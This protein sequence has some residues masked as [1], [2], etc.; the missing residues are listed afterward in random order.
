MKIKEIFEQKK[1]VISLE[2]FPPSKNY[3]YSRLIYDLDKF[4]TLDPDFISVTYSD[5]RNKREVFLKIND[6][7]KN[8]LGIEALSHLTCVNSTVAGVEE[9]LK[10][11]QDINVKNVLALRGDI[12]D[13]NDKRGD[14]KYASDL[15]KL[16]SGRDEF[17]IGAA[18][19]PEGHVE[20]EDKVKDI[21]HLRNKVNSGVDFLITQMFFDNNIFY[22]FMEKLELAGVDIPVSAGIMPV[23]SFK[24]VSKIIQLSGCKMPPKFQRILDKYEHNPEALREAGIYYAIEQIIDLLSFNTKGIHLYTMNNFKTAESI[25]G[26]I[27]NIRSASNNG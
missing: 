12:Y 21:L 2:V 4:K 20:A 13:E 8:H 6:Y 1:A 3:D 9:T 14:F 25:L 5:T 11:L 26:S 17:S 22:D 15:V 18:C 19:Y 23:T 24:S 27:S 10:Q 7:I 16:L